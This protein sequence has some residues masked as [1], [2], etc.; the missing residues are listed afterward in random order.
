MIAAHTLAL[1]AG[2]SA[3]DAI[4]GRFAAPDQRLRIKWPNDILWDGAKLCGILLERT[5]DAVIV[6][7]GI[8]VTG[9]P[10]DLGRPVTSLAAVGGGGSASDVIADLVAAFARTL[11]MWRVEGL[12][13]V[14]LAWRAR[15][16][17]PGTAVRVEVPDGEAISGVF[18]EL[19]EDGALI[20]RLANGA[21]RAIHTG[22]VFLI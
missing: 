9:H 15:A 13:A 1:V 16:L 12:R 11:Q 3:Y 4:A 5:G 14:A 17:A 8:N 2:V 20:L 7:F 18:S 6:G 21:T 19:A 10:P 22:D